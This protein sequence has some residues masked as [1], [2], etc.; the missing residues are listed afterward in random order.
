MNIFKELL[1]EL[2]RLNNNIERLCFSDFTNP[3]KQPTW[4]GSHPLD[5]LDPFKC[6]RPKVGDNPLKEIRIT[7]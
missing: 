2:R 1:T 5:P 6:D 7:C 4:T 3:Y